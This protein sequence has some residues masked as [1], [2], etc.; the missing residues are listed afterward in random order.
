MKKQ[1][2]GKRTRSVSRGFARNLSGTTEGIESKGIFRK[3]KRGKVVRKE[4]VDVL[5]GS[6]ERIDDADATGS[7]RKGVISTKKKTVKNKEGEYTKRKERVLYD[8]GLSSVKRKQKKIRFGKNKG[9]VRS[10]TVSWKDGKR[11][12]TK[13][14]NDKM[15]KQKLQKG[16]FLLEPGIESID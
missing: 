15:N 5:A 6:D 1:K 3:N 8:D 13:S 4:R 12:V 2:G 7:T 11:T 10:K 16:G 14:I 9:K